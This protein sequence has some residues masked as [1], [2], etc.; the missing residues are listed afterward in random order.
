MA[1]GDDNT[2]PYF[3]ETKCPNSSSLLQCSEIAFLNKSI[4]ISINQFQPIRLSLRRRRVSFTYFNTKGVFPTGILDQ[5]R[6]NKMTLHG[7][8]LKLP[9]VKHFEINASSTI[10]KCMSHN[11]HGYIAKLFIFIHQPEYSAE[12]FVSSIVGNT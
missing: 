1:S 9:G 8:S 2:H 7:T 12:C 11:G 6:E 5:T 3:P 10:L 4:V